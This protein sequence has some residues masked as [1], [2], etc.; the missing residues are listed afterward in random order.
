PA[1]PIWA[2]NFSLGLPTSHPTR[3]RPRGGVCPQSISPSAG[4][5]AQYY[6]KKT[7]ALCF[8]LTHTAGQRRLTGGGG[9]LGAGCRRRVRARGGRQGRGRAAVRALVA[10]AGRSYAAAGGG[11]QEQRG[12]QARALT[13]ATVS[14][15]PTRAKILFRH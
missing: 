5:P 7:L 4:S 2:A 1:L 10:A 9:Q 13:P 6:Q 15:S 11:R 12:Q 3:N 14:L 8:S